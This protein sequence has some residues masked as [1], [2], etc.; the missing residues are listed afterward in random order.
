MPVFGGLD[1]ASLE[2]LSQRAAAVSVGRGRHFF[3]EGEQG[4]AM[5]VLQAGRVEIYRSW[6]GE[7]KLLRRMKPGDCFGEMALID[8]SP[9]SASVLALE[10]CEALEIT[11]MLLQALHEQNSEQFTL[12]HMN[13]SREISRRLRRVDELLFRALMGDEL[14]ETSFEDYS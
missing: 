9:R 8:L 14:P 11:P 7:S 3:L 2:L 4:Q 10:D 12:L 5:Y 6:Q 1:A 13:I